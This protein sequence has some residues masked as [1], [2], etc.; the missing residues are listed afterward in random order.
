[1]GQYD[2]TSMDGETVIVRTK[3]FLNHGERIFRVLDGEGDIRCVQGEW[4]PASDR[5]ALTH[6]RTGPVDLYVSSDQ[7]WKLDKAYRIAGGFGWWRKPR[8]V[9]GRLVWDDHWHGGALATKDMH[10]Q[11]RRQ[12]MDYTNGDNGFADHGPDDPDAFR[13]K[14]IVPFHFY[15]GVVD[16]SNLR[17]EAMKSR[18]FKDIKSVRLHQRALNI[19]V[20]AHLS[21][22][23]IYGPMTKR[24]T[25]KW[26]LQN[27]WEQDGIPGILSETI[28]QGALAN[29][30]A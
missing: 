22:D 24:A 12:A 16:L 21:V 25:K 7:Y 9:D 1:M 14:V 11:A 5:S 15:L 29:V 23:G 2:R 10:E 4:Q 28:L 8:W 26:E 19:K 6:T 3:K 20:N 30:N 17:A 27:G 13:P 18:G